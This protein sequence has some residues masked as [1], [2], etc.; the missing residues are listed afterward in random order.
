MGV[1]ILIYADYVSH[2][3]DGNEQGN[4]TN[5]LYYVHWL[6]VHQP[7]TLSMAFYNHMCCY[8]AII[9]V[10]LRILYTESRVSRFPKSTAYQTRQ[11]LISATPES[12]TFRPLVALG[13]PL[14]QLLG[15]SGSEAHLERLRFRGQSRGNGIAVNGIQDRA[16]F[17]SF[18]GVHLKRSDQAQ[19]GRV[20]FP[21]GQV[22]AS[23][24]ARTSTIAIVRGT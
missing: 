15:V 8:A 1:R 21:V 5:T 9:F 12:Q 14:L 22:R 17:S 19:E 7:G 6:Q 4:Q 24:H 16:I 23:A 13:N 11:A 2:R 20:Q 18:G 10:H 3:R